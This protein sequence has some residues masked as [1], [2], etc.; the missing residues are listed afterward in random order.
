MNHYFRHTEPNG[1]A[2]AIIS[3]EIIG[4]KRVGLMKAYLSGSPRFQ[5][6]SKH[7]K[8]E[9]TEGNLAELLADTTDENIPF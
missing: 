5:S 6:L 7:T 2:V 8:V 3:V 4:A 1:K 9:F